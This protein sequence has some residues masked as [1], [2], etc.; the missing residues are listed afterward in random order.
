MLCRNVFRDYEKKIPLKK[1]IVP[2]A[3]I[4]NI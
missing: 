2:V 4:F 3:F 1:L